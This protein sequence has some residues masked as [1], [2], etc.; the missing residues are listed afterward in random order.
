MI[1]Q[2]H[3]KMDHR[4]PLETIFGVIGSLPQGQDKPVKQAV[5]NAV[6]LFLLFLCCAAAFGLY[7]IL[8]PFVKPLMWAI[9]VGSAL[10]PL[11]RS[12]RDRFQSWFQMLEDTNTPAVLGLVLLPINIFNDVSEIIG[13]FLYARIKLILTITV[14]IPLAVLIYNFTPT[15]VISVLSTSAIWV[16]RSLNFVISNCTLTLVSI[17]LLGYISIVFLCWT[18]EN[19]VHFHYASTVVWL[20]GSCCL[21][22]QFGSIQMPVFIILQIVFF[23]GFISEVYE[24][25]STMNEAGHKISFTELLSIAFHDKPLDLDISDDFEDK[26]EPLE[27]DAKDS[28]IE[29][30]SS[31]PQ[32]KFKDPLDDPVTNDAKGDTAS[33]SRIESPSGSEDPWTLELFSDSKQTAQIESP[34][35]ATGVLITN[36]GIHLVQTPAKSKKKMRPTFQRSLSQPQFMSGRFKTS[37]LSNISRKISL[38]NSNPKLESN[39]TY[40]STFYLYSVMWLCLVML[41]WKNIMLMPLLPLPILYYIIKHLGTYLGVWHYIF[42]KS[43]DIFDKVSDWCVERHDALVPV[44]IRGLY[45]F[46]HKINVTAKGCIKGSIDTVASIVVIVGLIIFLITASIFTAIQIYAEAILLLQMISNAINQ[47]VVQNPELHQLLPPTWNETM[48]SLLDNAYQYGREGIS[49]AVKSIVKDADS[50]QSEKLEKQILELWDRIYQSWMMKNDSMG[51]K[52]TE[53]AVM[54]S[55]QAFVNDI[56]K[57]PAFAT[58]LGAIPF[59]GTYWACVPGILDLWL[60]QDRWIAAIL[61]AGFQFL[62]TSIVDTTI[63]SEIKGGHPYLTG[64]A[65]AGGIFCLG[66]EGALIGPLLLCGLYVAIDLSSNLFKES[67]TDEALNLGLH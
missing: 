7:W 47:T 52:V 18:Q 49:K 48:D 50:A 17:I 14:V 34:E 20:L 15:V 23:G 45:K 24:A 64:L 39:V 43:C 57:S 10:H 32:V 28:S 27:T 25:Y 8:E 1:F 3:R 22:S 2:A 21:S 54:T 12:L 29:P 59:L 44:P 42:E 63:Y 30:K 61:F 37:N 9:L 58:I 51:P 4:S 36:H 35:P 56:Q 40:E 67:P 41:F 62:P 26:I 65:I 19:N 53:D 31:T 60:S 16:Y 11:K 5:F 13:E 6:A 55:W 46:V 33:L 38:K 66:V